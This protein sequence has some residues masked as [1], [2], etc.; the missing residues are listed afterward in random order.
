LENQAIAVELTKLVVSS[1][2][3]TSTDV[4]HICTDYLSV[5]RYILNDLH[6]K[7]QSVNYPGAKDHSEGIDALVFFC[8]FFVFRPAN[9][10]SGL[11]V[12]FAR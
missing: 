2:P 5:Y 4:F 1:R 3:S 11:T 7:P 8:P 10:E 9:A 6:T 12:G